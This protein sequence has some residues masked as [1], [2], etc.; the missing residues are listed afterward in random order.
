MWGVI[1]L[2]TVISPPTKRAIMPTLNFKGKSIIR[3][4]HLSVP[5]R[6]LIPDPAK[7]LTDT[8]G[9]RDNLIIHGD[10]LLALKALLPSFAGKI[11]CIYIDPP[12]NT[13]NENWVYNDNVNSPM[14][15]DW[16]KSTVDKEDL[17]RHEKWLCMMWPRLVLLRDLLREDGAIFVSIDDNEVHHL[18]A[19][20]DEIF[21]EDHFVANIVWQKKQSPQNDATYLSDM[22][23]HILVYAKQPKENKSDPSGWQRQLL[24]RSKAQEARFTNPD[25]DPRGPWISVDY[26]SNKTAEQRPNLYYPVVNPNTK[27]EVWPSRQTVWRFEKSA[28]AKNLKENRIWWSS[29]GEGF[30]RLKR[31][32]SEIQSGVVPSTWWTREEFGDNQESRRELR[33]LFNDRELDFETPKPVRLIKRILQIAT[34][35]DADEIVLDSFAG[36][37]TT[38]HAVL[39]ANAEDGGNRRFI[40]VEQEDYADR[41]T[42]ERIRRI[43]RG[44]PESKD[45]LL[46]TGYSST[47]SYFELGPALDDESLLSG[48]T[49]PSYLE[50]A[51]YVFFTATGE[52][53]D[54]SQVDPS[55]YYLGESRLYHVYLLYQPDVEFLKTTPLNLTFAEQLPKSDKTRLVIASHKYLDDDR[56]RDL[57]IEFCQLPFAIYRFK[58]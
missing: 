22:H 24:P 38:G 5:Y 34:T 29:T 3:T 41:L 45:E 28:H 31:F 13:G 8:P 11:K 17:T 2:A 40:L 32:R 36:S 16:L 25:N 44:V 23:D 53:L 19:I 54:D 39:A 42:A 1:Y 26:T 55:R 15:A 20:L 12:Y 49:L 37:G 35:G 10:N 9:L 57:R 50:L 47:F 27:Q 6:Q 4:H 48:E 51:R 14:H 30:P 52:R 33:G 21:G 18:R 58:A 46:R 43:I 7:S 56:L